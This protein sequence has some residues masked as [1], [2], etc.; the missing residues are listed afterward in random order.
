M[1]FKNGKIIRHEGF[2]PLELNEGNV[3]AIFNRCLK[4][5]ETKEIEYVA[6]IKKDLGFEETETP[7]HF[8]KGK[9]ETN[10]QAIKYLFGQLELVHKGSFSVNL[11]TGIIKHDGTR[12]TA[13]DAIRRM[14][15][16]LGAGAHIMSPFIP[17]GYKAGLIKLSPTL[18]PKDP[19]FPAW[20]EAHKSEWEQ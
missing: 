20:W 6:L 16:Y 10:K 7:V 15:F 12:W 2:E 11:D 13:N 19:N 4:S 1:G 14:F 18:S 5:S 8:D 17:E 3:Q 9:L